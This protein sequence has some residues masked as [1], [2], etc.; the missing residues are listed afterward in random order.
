MTIT[1]KHLRYNVSLNLSPINLLSG[2][3]LLLGTY[4]LVQDCTLLWIEGFLRELF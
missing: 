3:L 4:F 2:L 1:S